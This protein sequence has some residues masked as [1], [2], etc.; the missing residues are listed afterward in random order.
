MEALNCLRNWR[1]EFYEALGV[2]EDIQDKEVSEEYL[3]EEIL[4]EVINIM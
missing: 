4:N 1:R 3:D 2:G